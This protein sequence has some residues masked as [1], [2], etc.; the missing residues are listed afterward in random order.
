ML[1]DCDKITF[2]AV[3]ALQGVRSPLQSARFPVYASPVLFAE[4]KY[5]LRHRRN[6]RYEWLATT[7][8]N[9]DFHSVRDARLGLA[10]LNL[11]PSDSDY[12]YRLRLQMIANELIPN[13][14][15]L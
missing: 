4:K 2:E 12:D 15:D 7:L 11:N 3:P 9:R 14:E 1:A 13:S 5:R 6:P 8:L 10:H